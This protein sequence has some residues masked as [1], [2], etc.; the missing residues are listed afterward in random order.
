[1]SVWAI[2]QARL[3]ARAER[4][5]DIRQGERQLSRRAVRPIGQPSSRLGGQ[6]LDRAQPERL[7]EQR[8]A[9]T[10]ELTGLKREQVVAAAC[11]AEYP[12]EIYDW[13][14]RVDE[15]AGRADARWQRTRQL[16][17]SR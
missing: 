7:A 15:E 16:L 17:S 11:Y 4:Q 9:R 14:Q 10:A 6:P 13:I 1:M 3:G 12:D 8:A 2:P 5:P